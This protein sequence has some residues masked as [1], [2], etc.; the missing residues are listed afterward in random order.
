MVKSR[1]LI[2]ALLLVAA[3]AEENDIAPRPNVVLISIDSLRQ[4][5]LGCYGH[6]LEFAPDL[7]VSPNLDHLA[8]VGERFM[9]AFTSTSWTLPSHAALMTGLNDRAHGVETGSFKIDP[10]HEVLAELFQDAGWRTFGVYSGGF[11]DPRHGFSRGFDKYES[12]ILDSKECQDAVA[13]EMKLVEEQAPDIEWNSKRIARLRKIILRYQNR[14]QQVSDA[15]I[16]MLEDNHEDGKPFFLF[17]HFFDVHH[18]YLPERIDPQ[19]ALSFDP[20]YEGIWTG[21][22]WTERAVDPGTRKPNLGRRDLAHVMA[23]YDAEVH[24]VDR[25]IGRIF[26]WLKRNSLWDNTIVVVVSDHGEEF[27]DHG[28]ITHANNLHNELI[29]IP[30]FLKEAKRVNSITGNISEQVVG[31]HHIAPTLLQLAGVKESCNQNKRGILESNGNEGVISR[32][33]VFSSSN[34][35]GNIR[36]AWRDQEYSV[37]RW[38]R[39]DPVSGELKL[40]THPKTNQPAVLIYDLSQDPLEQS[41][42]NLSDPR[43]TIAL[44]RFHRDA[45]LEEKQAQKISQSPVA[46]R[47]ANIRTSEETEFLEAL[48]YALAPQEIE[49]TSIYF[50]FPLPLPNEN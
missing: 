15:A 6:E 16:T 50:S 42:L 12:A 5:R 7:K 21:K 35:Q 9:N 31:I 49:D 44:K 24:L 13:H 27:F 41:P 47:L 8:K 22:D 46:A 29:R 32:L 40:A 2:I 14:G 25:Q 18:D 39:P 20:T 34:R 10:K 3:C 1:I 33:Q 45:M 11:L 37:L 30:L 43:A 28:G 26:A 4:D 19:L 17:T 38:F 23:M 48:G 36:D